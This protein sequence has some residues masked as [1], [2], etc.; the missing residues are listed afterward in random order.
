MEKFKIK[1]DKIL[2]LN[3]ELNL[4][5]SNGI[6]F[7]SKINKGSINFKI[8]NES[9]QEVNLG[10]LEE[11][12]LIKIYGIYENNETNINIKIEQAN[13][14]NIKNNKIKQKNN[15]IIKKIIIKN[16]YIF[17]SESSEDLDN[18]N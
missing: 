13:E 9:N 18:Y 8:F 11:G 15:I 16:K 7:K 6:N 2:I 1:I 5:S 17:N 10:N 4:L 3:N 14:N 12:T